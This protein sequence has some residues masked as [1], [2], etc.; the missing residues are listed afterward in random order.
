MNESWI[1]R[2]DLVTKI[3]SKVLIPPPR[4]FKIQPSARKVMLSAFQDAENVI[5]V[6][7]L[8]GAYYV[9]LIPTL[10]ALIEEKHWEKL[11]KDVLLH[12]D[13]ASSHKSAIIK[14]AIA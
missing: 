10:R 5:F 6:T 14:A 3:Q 2:H 8:T 4:K 11:R 12:Q 13:N 1:H 7:T 9:N